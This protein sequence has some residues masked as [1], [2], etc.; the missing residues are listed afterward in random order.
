MLMEDGTT[1]VVGEAIRRPPPGWDSRTNADVV[2]TVC[3]YVCRL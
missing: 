1:P 2:C 3:M